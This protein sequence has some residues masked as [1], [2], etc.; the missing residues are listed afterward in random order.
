MHEKDVYPSSLHFCSRLV[1]FSRN[2]EDL[3]KNCFK[4]TVKMIPYDDFIADPNNLI[5]YCKKIFE[6]N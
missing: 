1:V 2:R 5:L 4:K 6:E 3:K